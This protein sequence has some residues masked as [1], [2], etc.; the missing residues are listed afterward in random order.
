MR[1]P[2]STVGTR[3]T[4]QSERAHPDQVAN[5]AGG[6]SFPVDDWGR[7]LRFLVLG[8]DGG[9]YYISEKDLTM[10]NAEV[11][12][13]LANGA[14]GRKLVDL[15]VDVSK[16]GRAPRQNPTLYALAACTASPDVNTRRAALA[17]IP[18]VCRTGT[19]LFIFARYVEQFRGWGRGL[20]RAIGQWYTEKSVD[21]VAFQAV[22]YQQREG[23]SHRDLLRLSHPET[24]DPARKALFSH[25]THG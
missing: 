18:V 17:A 13:R 10:Q 22:K 7:A 3:V 19:H 6:Y 4:P 11:V 5:S 1:D 25:I 23:W 21:D 20:K 2:L 9:T 14:E 8:T 16:N 12:I 24:P 15:I